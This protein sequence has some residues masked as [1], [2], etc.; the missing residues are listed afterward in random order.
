MSGIG[1]PALPEARLPD[2]RRRRLARLPLHLAVLAL[3]AAAY[4]QRTLAKTSGLDDD[5]DVLFLPAIARLLDNGQIEVDLQAWIFERE[6]IRLLDAGLARY[7]G[8]QLEKLS[9]TDR[10]RYLRRTEMFHAEPEE[11][12]SLTVE[13]GHGTPTIKMPASNASGRTGLRA[14]VEHLPLRPMSMQS[15]LDKSMS[16]VHF[17][18]VLGGSPPRRI[19]GRALLVPSEGLSVVSDIDDTV[20]RT[21]VRNQHQMMLNTFARLF[22]AVP[23]M[24]RRYRELAREPNTC[25]HYLSSS[26]LQLLPSLKR[27]LNEAK[28]PPG[29]MHLRESTRMRDWV[30]ADGDSR[31]HK[32]G[33]L[34]RLVADFPNRRFLLVGDSGEVDPEV[35]GEMARTRTDRIEAVLIRDVTSEGRNAERYRQAFAGVDESRWH[36]FKDGEDWPLG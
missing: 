6:R 9:A 31:A 3:A 36:I 1:R 19:E 2:P 15:Q 24:A 25:F 34:Q 8:I 30:P 33:V 10:L 21:D 14:V 27:F 7:L 17:H 29:S 22:E 12:K 4:P 35:Y 13:F 26:P 11:G 16:W 18:T 5:E 20:K 23:G 28:F 32:L